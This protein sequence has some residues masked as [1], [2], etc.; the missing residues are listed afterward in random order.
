MAPLIC[1][2]FPFFFWKPGVKEKDIQKQLHKWGKLTMNK[3]A[4]RKVQTEKR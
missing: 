1:L 2:F 4:Q 3:S